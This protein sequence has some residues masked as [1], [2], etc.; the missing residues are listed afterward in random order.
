MC[1]RDSRGSSDDFRFCYDR[2]YLAASLP[3]SL[4]FCSGF[5]AKRI[6]TTF[7]S[8]SSSWFSRS[9]EQEL[10]CG[11]SFPATDLS[12]RDHDLQRTN[13]PEL[14]ENGKYPG[15]CEL[16]ITDGDLGATDLADGGSFG[17]DF[18][19][20]VGRQRRIALLL[21]ESLPAGVDPLQVIGN[22]TAPFGIGSNLRN[23]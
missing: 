17:G 6:P 21:S 8:L 22:G 11:P 2:V 23:I 20:Q 5:H 14:F 19:K 7:V 15:C 3:A 9:S 4:W 10:S 1:S 16:G 13:Q 18:G 12:R